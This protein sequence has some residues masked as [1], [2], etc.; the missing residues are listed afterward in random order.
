M[1]CLWVARESMFYNDM[2]L[3]GLSC[4]ALARFVFCA[5]LT[6]CVLIQYGLIKFLTRMNSLLLTIWLRMS[7]SKC[8]Y[9]IFCDMHPVWNTVVTGWIVQRFPLNL[10]QENLLRW[11][12]YHTCALLSAKHIQLL[13]A[14]SG[15]F[16]EC[17]ASFFGHVLQLLCPPPSHLRC[18]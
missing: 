8:F 13:L 10:W 16:E 5:S 12:S 18:C 7:L 15:S 17:E 9:K 1:C 11:K 6:N 4:L 3:V 14:A 2:T